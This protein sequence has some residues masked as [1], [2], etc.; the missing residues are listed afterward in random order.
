MTRRLAFH[1]KRLAIHG[2]H[3]LGV[4]H[5]CRRI[6]LQRRAVVLMYHRV[7]PSGALGQTW[8]HPGIIVTRETFDRHMAVLKKDFTPLTA[9]AFERALGREGRFEPGSCLV[10]FDDG[11]VDTYEEALPAL[12]RHGIPAVV[13]LPTSFIGTSEV[14]W[15]ERLG[16]VVYAVW[17]Q[18]RRDPEFVAAARGR[19]GEVGLDSVLGLSDSRAREQIMD[20]VRQKKG[21]WGQDPSWPV[22]VLSAIPGLEVDPA[23]SVDRFMNWDQVREMRAAGVTFGGHGDTHRQLT[24]LAADQVVQEVES[25]RQKIEAELGERPSAFA[26]PNGDWNETVAAA[27][28]DGRFSIAFSTRPGHVSTGDSP[29]SIRRINMHEDM[30]GT[31]PMFLARVLGLI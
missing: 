17:K 9:S 2:L 28:R 19:L 15:Q 25:S 31:T 18:A 6:L 12:R 24:T 8:S 14:F 29:H 13:F 20:L 23:D 21:V 26:Y 27:V 1:A 16:A 30:T 7:L 10:T 11:W 4:L 22:R 3:A 5:L